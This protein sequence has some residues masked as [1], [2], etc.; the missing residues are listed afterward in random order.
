[1]RMLKRSLISIVRLHATLLATISVFLWNAKAALAASPHGAH[2]DHG[3]EVMT[4]EVI[5]EHAEASGSLPQLDI[6]TYPSQIFWL[7]ITFAVL[8]LF[9]KNKTLPEISSTLENRREYIQSDLETAEKLKAEAE[10]VQRNYE[11][12]LDSARTETAHMM[13]QVHEDIDAEIR[14]R[15][16]TFRVKADHEIKALE[17]RIN[18]AK[19]EAMDDMHLIVAEVASE[20]AQKIVGLSADVN[21][22]RTFIEALN[23][24]NFS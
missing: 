23:G 22:V 3:G 2:A 12:K 14:K 16:E 24:R 10:E 5:G 8:Y 1:M 9:F 6:S 20:A 15:N 18:K 17:T 11:S 21:Q 4:A 7:V 19:A 13:S